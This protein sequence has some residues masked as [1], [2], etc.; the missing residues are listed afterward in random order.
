MVLNFF[1]KV[2]TMPC[3][4]RA[5][6]HHATRF[7]VAYRNLSESESE[8]RLDYFRIEASFCDEEQF[9][10]RRFTNANTSE[11]SR[12]SFPKGKSR[13]VTRVIKECD[14]FENLCQVCFSPPLIYCK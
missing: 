10:K 1:C 6:Y 2:G 4:S 5:G 12:K 8:S 9:Q 11:Y 13:F 3:L 14:S 7:P